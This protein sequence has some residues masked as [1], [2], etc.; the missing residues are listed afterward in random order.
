MSD[1][2]TR[3]AARALGVAEAA[4]PRRSI[5]EPR[6]AAAEPLVLEPEGGREPEARAER[7]ER[8]VVPPAPLARAGAEARQASSVTPDADREPSRAGVP[9]RV[10]ER[11]A[12]LT[13][14]V[15]RVPAEA[16]SVP[17]DAPQPGTPESLREIEARE[18]DVPPREPSAPGARAARVE[19]PLLPL[20]ARPPRTVVPRKEA[21]LTTVRVTIGRVDVRAVSPQPRPEPRKRESQPPPR[22]SL[23]EYLSRPRERSR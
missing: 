10:P 16:V 5:F 3:L 13:R 14:R 7:A 12:R 22:M 9:R 18:P 1:Y 4:R 15:S 6:R 8:T 2:L 11:T 20:A 23:E 21:P 17:A 19:P